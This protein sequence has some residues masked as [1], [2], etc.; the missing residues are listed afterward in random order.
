MNRTRWIA[1]TLGI[2]LVGTAAAEAARGARRGVGQGR[3]GA[4]RQCGFVDAD[5]DGTCDRLQSAP[6][7]GAGQCIRAGRQGAAGRGAALGR[8][9]GQ[10]AGGRQRSLVQGTPCQG[11][12]AGPGFL[13][14]GQGRRAQACG[15][16]DRLQRRLRDRSCQAAP[17]ACPAADAAEK[18]GE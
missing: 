12:G 8:G 15:D 2:V 17:A 6:A 18:A 1:L 14:R 10:G 5:G 3:Q 16:A 11:A 13:G 9:R 4:G 7:G